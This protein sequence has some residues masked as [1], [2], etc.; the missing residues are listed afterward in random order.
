MGG[1]WYGM[2]SNCKY[3]PKEPLFLGCAGDEAHQAPLYY[4]VLAGWQRLVDLPARAPFRGPI[5]ATSFFAHGPPAQRGLF[6]HHS[7]ADLRFLLWLRIP[8]V[9]MGAL[10]VLFVF[11]AVRLVTADPWTPV[12]GAAIVAFLPRFIFL[13]SFITNDNLVNLLGAILTVVALRYALQP[14][15]W[16]MAAVGV[17]VGLLMI[18]KLSALP[19]ALVLVV[20][21]LMAAGWKR[22]VE[23]SRHR[24]R[25]N[26]RHKR[27]VFHPEHRPV[28]GSHGESRVGSLPVPGRWS[29]CVDRGDVQ[30][31][32]S[33]EPGSRPCARPFAK[34]LLVSIGLETILLAVAG[35][36]PVLTCARR[37]RSRTHSSAPE[38]HESLF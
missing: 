28:W 5:V 6:T 18:T 33:C 32:Q 25:R 27:L 30:D 31:W 10:T 20:L 26:S 4:L 38:P 11:F 8:N 14:S 1:H 2:N 23:S 29:G 37:R 24:S 19:I 21:A 16:R 9:F 13:S 34:Q 7:A 17:V 15:R 35:Q 22:R 3:S 12:V 36:S